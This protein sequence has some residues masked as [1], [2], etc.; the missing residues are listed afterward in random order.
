M[1]LELGGAEPLCG[2][3]AKKSVSFGPAIAPFP[4]AMPQ[5]PGTFAGSVPRN[6][7]P[8]PSARRLRS[9]RCRSSRRAASR[10]RRPKVFGASPCPTARSGRPAARRARRASR[11]GRTRRRSRRS[12]RR[13]RSPARGR[14]VLTKTASPTPGCRTARTTPGSRVDERAAPNDAA[15]LRVEHEHAVV[16]EVGRVERASAG[17]REPA[18]DRA[19]RAPRRP[20]RRPPSTSRAGRPATSRGSSRPRT[21]R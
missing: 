6:D 20:R 12:E 18:E 15:P 3:A 19:L 2:P 8:D 10:R 16:V 4:N 14:R 17:E 21:R 5:R 13:S 11:R 9:A 7:Q 1:H